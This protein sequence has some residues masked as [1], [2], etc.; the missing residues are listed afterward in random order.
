MDCFIFEDELFFILNYKNGNVIKIELDIYKEFFVN[1]LEELEGMFKKR[2][3]LLVY[4]D[5]LF[6]KM[7]ECIDK[8]GCS[9][10]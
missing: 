8:W 7:L 3:D 4:I 9:F 10:E 1:M 2:F 6:D 5:V